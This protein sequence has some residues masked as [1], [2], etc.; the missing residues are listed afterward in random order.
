MVLP[1]TVETDICNG[2]PSFDMVGL[3]S[4]DTKEARERVRTALKN[5]GFLVPPK[6][7]T[8]NFSPGN[9][10]KSGTYFDLAI[11]ISILQSLGV[12]S[13]DISKMIF[14]GE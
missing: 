5:S 10:R 8:I 1:V 7:I 14:I 13:K 12:I 9:L 6:R 11:A 4:S 2:L 3:L